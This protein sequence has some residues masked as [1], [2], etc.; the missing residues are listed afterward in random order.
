MKMLTT[1]F[2]ELEYDPSTIVTLPKG[3]IGFPEYT[4]WLILDQA[5]DSPFKYMQS[6]DEGA[7]AFL[8]A[9][10]DVLSKN[11]KY[12]PIISDEDLEK[13]SDDVAMSVIITMP[14]NPNNA[15]ANLKAP[16]VWDLAT[17]QGKQVI[18]KS[19][20]YHTRHN[21]MEMTK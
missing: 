3:L 13:Y 8:I 14:M 11:H 18:S 20:A 6:I 17:R 4:N 16:I 21:V 10:P 9:D 7:I 12:V 2:G 1:R 5:K 19:T 15:T